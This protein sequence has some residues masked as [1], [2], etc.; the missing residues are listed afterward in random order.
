VGGAGG[1]FPYTTT[2][3]AGFTFVTNVGFTLSVQ[4]TKPDPQT[5]ANPQM[6]KSFLNLARAMFSGFGVGQC[7]DYDSASA[8]ARERAGL[9]KGAGKENAKRGREC[10]HD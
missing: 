6:T 8:Y 3:A 4:A 5:G 1:L 10:R 7:G 2:A 9:L